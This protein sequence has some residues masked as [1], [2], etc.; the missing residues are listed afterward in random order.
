[1]W[2][3]KPSK[4]TATTKSLAEFDREADA[5]KLAANVSNPHSAEER[6]A[7]KVKQRNEERQRKFEAG[8]AAGEPQAAGKSTA[9][10]ED[11]EDFT[12]WFDVQPVNNTPQV[13]TV[14]RR[15]CC[16]LKSS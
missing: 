10:D 12:K 3:G 5:A 1:M 11:E 2:T 7:A 4:P 8:K 14:Q 9:E 15:C 13:F 16:R 6:K